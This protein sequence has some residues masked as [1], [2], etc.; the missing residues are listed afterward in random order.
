MER[1][2]ERVLLNK[3]GLDFGSLPCMLDYKNNLLKEMV[4]I[5]NVPK[6]ID[7]DKGRVI[8]HTHTI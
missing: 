3:R 8:K 4:Q 1:D 6:V 2:R 5:T 7:L